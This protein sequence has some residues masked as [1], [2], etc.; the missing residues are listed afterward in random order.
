MFENKGCGDI[1]SKG[2]ACRGLARVGKG[3][4]GWFGGGSKVEQQQPAG[5]Q[6]WWREGERDE[7]YLLFCIEFFMI[8]LAKCLA[9]INT[10]FKVKN[11]LFAN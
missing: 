2:M 5:L 10:F 6:P 1:L 4:S 9:Y 11:W 3:A 7:L 8:D